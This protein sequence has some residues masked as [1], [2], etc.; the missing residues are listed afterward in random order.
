MDWFAP[1]SHNMVIGIMLSNPGAC[2]NPLETKGVYSSTVPSNLHTVL[3]SRHVR[4]YGGHRGFWRPRGSVLQ[5]AT[6]SH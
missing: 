3:D 5:V 2:M 4:L 6:V 1:V